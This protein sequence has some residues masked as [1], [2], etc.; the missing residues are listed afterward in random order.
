MRHIIVLPDVHHLFSQSKKSILSCG[1]LIDY[2]IGQLS[3]TF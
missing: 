2:A 3:S 1:T